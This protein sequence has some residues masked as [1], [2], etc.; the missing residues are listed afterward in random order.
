MNAL[1][2]A[3]LPQFGDTSL[4]YAARGGYVEVASLLLQRGADIE[5]K[6]EVRIR[7]P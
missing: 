4:I 5:A 7:T 1:S 3:L 2:H 6:N